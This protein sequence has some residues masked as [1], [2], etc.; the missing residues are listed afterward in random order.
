MEDARGKDAMAGRSPSWAI[1]ILG[2]ALALVAIAAVVIGSR[3][4]YVRHGLCFNDPTW[5]F[6]FGRRIAHGDVPYRDFVFQVGPLPIYIDAA[7]QRVLGETYAASLD[8][9]IG[10]SIVRVFVMWL[11]VKRLAGWP[12]AALV[13]AFC[14]F[15]PTFATAHHWSTQ[16]AQLFV[17]LSGLFFV[18]AAQTDGRRRLAHLALAGVSAALVLSARQ[19]AGIMIGVVLFATTAFMMVVRRELARRNLVV[20]WGGFAMGVVLLLVGLALIGA[21]GPGLQQM[22]LDAPEKK[23]IHGLDAALDGISG[24]SLVDGNFA[25][26][27]SG[28]LF[29]LGLP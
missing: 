6:H 10:L 5:F 8:A 19:S 11:L 15:E 2:D 24:G 9:A 22:F 27:W 25:H 4:L 28:L 1:A 18:C 7:F 16:Y 3:L 21:L 12:A 23:G 26:W 13:A 14:T 17:V 20:L 29:W